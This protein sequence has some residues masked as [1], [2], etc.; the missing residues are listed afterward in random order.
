MLL[1]TVQDVIVLYHVVMDCTRG[2]MMPR[3]LRTKGAKSVRG[4]KVPRVP[5]LKAQK[6]Y[7]GT[8]FSQELISDR[9][10]L[11]KK[12]HLVIIIIDLLWLSVNG[13][14]CYIWE[15]LPTKVL[16]ENTSAIAEVLGSEAGLTKSKHPTTD[17]PGENYCG[18]AYATGSAN[19][20]KAKGGFWSNLFSF[21]SSFNF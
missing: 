21:K 4:Q 14:K 17:C 7:S 6:V 2:Q 12:V 1:S 3:G 11:L 8:G 13:I 18:A 19:G 9:A 16:A 15:D 10:W 5:R 20:K